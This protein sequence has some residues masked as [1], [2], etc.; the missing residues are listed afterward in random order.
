MS[1]V[2]VS[3]VAVS[4]VAVSSV[5]VSLVL[6]VSSVA[7]AP[8]AAASTVVDSPVGVVVA[9]DTGSSISAS[10]TTAGVSATLWAAV[11]A[12][13]VVVKVC[14]LLLDINWYRS[15]GPSSGSCCS[16]SS[17]SSHIAEPSTLPSMLLSSSSSRD[18]DT[19]IEFKINSQ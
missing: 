16:T 14:A 10:A 2:A 12:E 17:F 13:V 1:L 4:S 18:A 9:S 8:A 7:V 6:A 11:V 15:V 3:L 5:A 19:S